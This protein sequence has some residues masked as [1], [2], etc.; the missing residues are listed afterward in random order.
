MT[1]KAP[2]LATATVDESAQLPQSFSTITV[3]DPDEDEKVERPED[4]GSRRAESKS[5]KNQEL[6]DKSSKVSLDYECDFHFSFVLRL[7]C[8]R[9][10]F[11]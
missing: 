3:S 6:G 5:R 8:Q 11:C 4:S 2:D 9:G 7:G 1:K 10:V